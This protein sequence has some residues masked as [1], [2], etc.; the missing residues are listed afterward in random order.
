[1]E[2]SSVEPHL[3]PS[4]FERD[5]VSVQ[6]MAGD[7]FLCHPFLV[8]RASWPHRGRVPRVMAQPSIWLKE[9]YALTDRAGAL[10]V[11]RAIIAG[12]DAA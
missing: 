1:M 4:T 8:H 5:V 11:E 9:P 7:V 3:P 2:W 6:G 12:L 10:P